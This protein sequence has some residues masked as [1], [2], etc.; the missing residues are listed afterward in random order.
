MAEHATDPWNLNWV[1]PAEGMVADTPAAVIFAGG[2]PEPADVDELLPAHRF[3][4]AADS[5]LHLALSI[6]VDVDLVVGDLDSADPGAVRRALAAGAQVER[7]PAAKDA[8]D[9]ELALLAAAQRGLHP[10]VVVGGASLDRIDHFMANALLLAA[11]RWRDLRPEWFVQGAHVVAIHDAAR[12]RGRPG[13]TVTVLAVGGPAAGVTTHGLRW[14]LQ[15]DP[16]EPGSTRGVSNEM[17]DPVAEISVEAGSLL[18]I[19]IT[20]GAS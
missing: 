20:G 6:G 5:G 15:G 3:V 12:L 18:A 9:L 2:D 8:T 10:A 1:I 4:I 11:P 19:H 7:H 16:L 14:A 17:T 13:D